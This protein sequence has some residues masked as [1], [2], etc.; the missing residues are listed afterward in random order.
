MSET[1]N[2][3][4]SV[5]EGEEKYI[6][7]YIHQADIVINTAYSFEIG[8]MKVFVE[9]LLYSVG[10]DSPYYEEARRSIKS[11]QGYISKDS[12]LREFIGKGD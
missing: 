9:P 8:V 3:W 10:L 2:L 12:I 1:I 7:P 11:L 5:R 6:F 4:Q